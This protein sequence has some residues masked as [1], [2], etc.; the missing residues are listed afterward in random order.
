[1][2]FGSSAVR[3]G[4]MINNEPSAFG[5]QRRR[6]R[7]ERSREV[8][9]DVTRDNFEEALNAL[10]EAID[11]PLF[12]FWRCAPRRLRSDEASVCQIKPLADDPRRI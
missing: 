8:A 2:K 3:T 7:S 10:Q 4:P 5:D 6:A 12:A 1:M 9:M 11:D